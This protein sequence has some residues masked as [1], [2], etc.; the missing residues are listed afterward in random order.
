MFFLFGW[1]PSA[2]CGGSMTDFNGVILS[3]G[4][5]GNYQSSLDCTWGVQLPIGFGIHLQFLNFS[6]EPVH[7][8]LE[9]RSGTLETGTV[10]DRFSG[11][12]VPNSLFST[13]HETT[14]FFHSDYSQNKPGFHI[15]Y[16]A[17]E[18][19][20]CPDPHPFR[21]GIV[22]GQ[23]YSVGMTISFECLPGYTLI[24]EA[25]LTCLHGVSRNWNHPI[26]RCEG[27]GLLCLSNSI[28]VLLLEA[29]INRSNVKE[30][31]PHLHYCIRP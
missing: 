3:P 7:D 16:Q 27:E 29:F 15:V 31:A 21:N 13:T 22:I 8:Y 10:I 4:F 26:P 23:D 19:Q 17:Y 20:R 1:S 25:S 6:T 11:P 28:C 9:V 14:L 2:Q 24:G 12:V 5:P 30:A 18:L